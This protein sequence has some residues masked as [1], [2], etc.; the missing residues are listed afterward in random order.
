MAEL[1]TVQDTTTT[2]FPQDSLFTLK[3]IYSLLNC[4]MVQAITLDDGRIMWLDEE[5]KLKPHFSNAKATQLLHA[6]GGM[7]NDYIAGDVLI[8]SQDEIQ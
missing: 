2:V 1:I 8:T 4:N 5:G 7:E 6:S 3:E